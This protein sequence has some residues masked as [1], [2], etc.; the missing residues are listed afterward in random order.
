[1][2]GGCGAASRTTPTAAVSDNLLEIGLVLPAAPDHTVRSPWPGPC[3]E[4][5]PLD[6]NLAAR[7]RK[8]ALRGNMEMRITLAAAV[9]AGRW[10]PANCESC[11]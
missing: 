11:G 7:G 8:V 2:P 6:A 9:A 1:M 4:R 10:S 3:G 5:H